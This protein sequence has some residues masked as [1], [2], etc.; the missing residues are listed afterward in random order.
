M[1]TSGVVSMSSS[2]QAVTRFQDGP[3]A[4]WSRA[5]HSLGAL[6][7]RSTGSTTTTRRPRLGQPGARR[8]PRKCHLSRGTVE[9]IMV[10]AIRNF[11]TLTRRDDIPWPTGSF[12]STQRRDAV[13]ATTAAAFPRPA[14]A[15]VRRCRRRQST[16]R[17]R[18]SSARPRRAPQVSS[19]PVPRAR[20]KAGSLRHGTRLDCVL[21]GYV[22]GNAGGHGDQKPMLS[23]SA[24]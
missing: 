19:F 8:L 17:V 16:P 7:V 20:V 3:S 18:L 9:T 1:R 11:R 10:V 22:I 21:R 23:P 6:A 15:P 2:Q 14:V 5:R 4:R 13:G 24:G 12:G